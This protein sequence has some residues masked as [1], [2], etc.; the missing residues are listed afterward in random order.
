MKQLR[1][2]PKELEAQRQNEATQR[3]ENADQYDELRTRQAAAH[4]RE[5]VAGLVY[6]QMSTLIELRS[7]KLATYALIAILAFIAYK[8]A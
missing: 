5:D 3:A 4:T 6:I 7:I 8:L 2:L 1:A